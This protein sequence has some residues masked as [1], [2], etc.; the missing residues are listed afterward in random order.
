MAIKATVRQ[1]RGTHQ[2]RQARG[3]NSLP[4]EF[5]GSR[6]HDPLARLRRPL[7]SIFSSSTDLCRPVALIAVD[8]AFLPQYILDAN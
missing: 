4:A 2:F 1:T 8:S 6:G 3:Y 7:A 5:G